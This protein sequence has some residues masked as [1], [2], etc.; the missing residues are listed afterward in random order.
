MKRKKIQMTLPVILLLLILMIC[1]LPLPGLLTK[2]MKL[3][4]G[5]QRKNLLKSSVQL[6]CPVILNIIF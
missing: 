1:I 4:S 6:R 2:L 5:S 3:L